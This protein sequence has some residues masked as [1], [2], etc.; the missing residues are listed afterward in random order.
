M[1]VELFPYI[2]G[3]IGGAPFD[4]NYKMEDAAI[5]PLVKK[6]QSE[7]LYFNKLIQ[8]LVNSLYAKI[9][10]LTNSK[11]QNILLNLKRN[12]HNQRNIESL[13]KKEIILQ[14]LEMSLSLEEYTQQ[15]LIIKNI[16]SEIENS[17]N[18]SITSAIQQLQAITNDFF[19]E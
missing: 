15:W 19:F 6:L 16:K 9:E 10:T 2:F 4:I 13:T 1:S 11:E 8:R 18:K 3:R 17:Y 7:E 14:D 5:F 12:I